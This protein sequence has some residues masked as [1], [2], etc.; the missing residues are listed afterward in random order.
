MYVHTSTY[1]LLSNYIL[2]V[3]I[4]LPKYLIQ[5]LYIP[6]FSSLYYYALPFG[7]E[8]IAHTHKL[9]PPPPPLPSI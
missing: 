6:V 1:F 8:E 3:S 2:V 4:Y 5:I 9:N 7:P